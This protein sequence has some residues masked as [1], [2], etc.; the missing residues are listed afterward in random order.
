[1]GVIYV[2]TTGSDETGDGSFGNPYLTIQKG[3]DQA[4]NEDTVDV[5][6]GTYV[7]DQITISKAISLYG[8]DGKNNTFIIGND[9]EK[10]KTGLIKITC[11]DDISINGFGIS[12]GTSYSGSENRFSIK[13]TTIN[14]EKMHLIT[15]NKIIGSNSVNDTDIGYSNQNTNSNGTLI[16]SSNEFTQIAG[17]HII[18]ENFTGSSEIQN[19]Q[20]ETGVGS[21]DSVFILSHSNTIVENIQKID[22]NILNLGIGN[23]STY[24]KRATGI[25]VVAGFGSMGVFSNLKISN[26]TFDGVSEFRRAM[27]L[28]SND[29]NDGEILNLTISGNKINF[30]GT[31]NYS[32]GTRDL[33]STSS[34]SSLSSVTSQSTTSQSSESSLSS[35]SDASSESSLTSVSNLSSISSMSSESSIIFTSSYSSL[36]SPSSNSSQSTQLLTTSSQSTSSSSSQSSASSSSLSTQSSAS[37]SSLSP[38]SI[39]SESTQ[40]SLTGPSSSSISSMSS[41]SSS[42][43]TS[44]SS[45]SS[46]SSVSSQSSTSTSSVSSE[47]SESSSTSESSGSSSSQ[48]SLSS[49]SSRETSSVSSISSQSSLSSSSTYLMTTSSTYI[50]TTSSSSVSSSSSSS[51]SSSSSSSSSSGSSATMSFPTGILLVG[52]ITNSN[53]S[54]NYFNGCERAFYGRNEDNNNIW[55]IET[56]ISYNEFYENSTNICWRNLPPINAQHNWWGTTEESVIASKF[57]GNVD[58]KPYSVDQSQT[59]PY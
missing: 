12:L 33:Y 17:N 23:K 49:L 56:I 53:I 29:L 41:A 47:S 11:P 3:I 39:S 24:D 42:T 2:K 21:W 43:E 25:S 31:R 59:I 50:L 52:K 19:N 55:P 46:L 16:I 15:N 6:S 45:N 58:Y 20:L 7:V 9:I 57:D 22:G 18:L 8:S 48:S 30:T 32:L 28:V 34:L 37:S 1:M 5:G 14:S 44:L 27:A 54:N 51:L 26:N 4:S 38:S 35:V 10:S 40:S 13:D 36:S